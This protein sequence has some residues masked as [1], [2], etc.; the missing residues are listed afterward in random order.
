MRVS[1]KNEITAAGVKLAP[2]GIVASWG[3]S[4]WMYAL[5]AGYV[6][7]QALYL[8]WKWHREWKAKRG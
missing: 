8:V 7:L 6:V 2:V 5:T 3:P 1:L 4:E